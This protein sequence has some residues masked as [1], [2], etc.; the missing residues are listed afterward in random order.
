MMLHVEDFCRYFA[1]IVVRSPDTDV[2]LLL[3]SFNREFESEVYMNTG[4]GNN[5]RII[6][7]NSIANDF[8][9]EYCKGLLGLHGCDST[10]AFMKRGK[11]QPLNIMLKNSE[12]INTF[13]Q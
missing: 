13:N 9:P 1:S 7:N 4:V 3:L 5:R 6:K 11:I 12:Y 2:F 8:T 10:S